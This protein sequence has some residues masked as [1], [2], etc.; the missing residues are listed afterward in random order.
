MHRIHLSPAAPALRE[1]V[2]FYAHREV[3]AG[4]SA[5][6]H[7]VPAR[8]F[9]VLEFIFG[10]RFQ[11]SSHRRVETSPRVALVGLQTH[12]RTQ[13]RFQGTVECFVILF[14]PT[15]LQRLFSVPVHELTDRSCEAHSV[16]GGFVSRLEDLLQAGRN[17][18]QRARIADQFLLQHALNAGLPD[19]ISVAVTSILQA[20]GDARITALAHDA[21][22]SVRQFERC[23]AQQVGAHPKLYARIVRFESALDRKARSPNKSWTEVAQESGYYDQMH[24]IHDFGD[25]TGGTPSTILADLEVLFR[26][27]IDA[28]RAG[29]ISANG[30]SDLELIP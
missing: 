10:D 3:R 8:A 11:V 22:L 30:R 13:L 20:C 12:C 21:G 29:R 16:L 14:Q 18:G 4:R 15:G 26:E 5:V 28:I 25:F 19:R 7:P 1:F 9:P 23:F 2:K 24:M 27:R 17:F 6:E